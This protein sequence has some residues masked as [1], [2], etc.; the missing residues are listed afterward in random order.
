[1]ACIMTVDDSASMRLL[2]SQT[3]VGAGHTVV[4]AADGVEALKLAS[5]KRFDL[6]ICDVNMPQMDGLTLVQRLRAQPTHK[7]VPILMLTTEVDASKKKVAKDAGASG[8]LVKPF[9]PAVLL[10]TVQRVL[11]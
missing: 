1:M 6:F 11:P 4:Q 7:A 2:V 5:G 9:N 10:T 3:L 8:W